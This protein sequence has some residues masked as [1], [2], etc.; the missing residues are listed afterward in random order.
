MVNNVGASR[1]LD[2]QHVP[3]KPKRS[4]CCADKL[5]AWQSVSYLTLSVANLTLPKLHYYWNVL[6][7]VISMVLFPPDS[8]TV[9]LIGVLS[10]LPH[11]SGTI[12]GIAAISASTFA[13]FALTS[14]IVILPSCSL[15]NSEGA[16]G[17]CVIIAL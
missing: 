15:D 8:G 5:T 1:Q 17:V 9:I 14:S 10:M 11:S 3:E 2:R 6:E 12:L 16:F 4:T 13:L 7:S